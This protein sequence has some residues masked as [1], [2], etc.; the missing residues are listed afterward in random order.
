M[1]EGTLH[2]CERMGLPL[3]PGPP[4]L[5]P[6]TC[7]PEPSLLRGDP[8]APTGS[9]REREGTG[10][11]ARPGRGKA[12]LLLAG[13]GTVP[14]G[15]GRGW[16]DGGERGLTQGPELGRSLPSGFLSPRGVS[17]LSVCLLPA[18]GWGAEKG[19]PGHTLPWGCPAAP[20]LWISETEAH[21]LTEL[22]PQL[23]NLE[24]DPHR[25]RWVSI[26]LLEQPPFFLET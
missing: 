20:F 23:L 21:R 13:V 6:S 2:G 3:Q 24:W 17:S 18:G 25:E 1:W 15:Q 9:P 11:L 22:L 4:R 12:A 16:L 8:P 19:P 14:P 10:S 26:P 7:R 5:P